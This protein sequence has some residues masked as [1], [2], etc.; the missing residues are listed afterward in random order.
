MSTK[1]QTTETLNPWRKRARKSKGSEVWRETNPQAKRH[2]PPRVFL[3]LKDKQWQ[4]AAESKAV[5]PVE[6]RNGHILVLDIEAYALNHIRVA[7][8]FVRP[9]VIIKVIANFPGKTWNEAKRRRAV[10]AVRKKSPI[11]FSAV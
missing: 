4:L 1:S 6:R 9:K 2:A 8:V 3:R 5:T 11:L 10:A 7:D